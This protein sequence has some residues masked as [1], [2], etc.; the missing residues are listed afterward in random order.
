MR[1]RR[2]GY[3]DRPYSHH[4]ARMRGHPSSG[5][6]GIILLGALSRTVLLIMRHCPPVWF[7]A[8]WTL[9]EPSRDGACQAKAGGGDRPRDVALHRAEPHAGGR[10]RVGQAP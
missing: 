2:G 3:V 5:R 9:R 6:R 10:L 7:P 1:S 8:A 4:P